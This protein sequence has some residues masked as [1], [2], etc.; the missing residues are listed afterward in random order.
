M[1]STLRPLWRAIRCASSTR[2]AALCLSSLW[3]G[4]SMP[5]RW[6]CQASNRVAIFSSCCLIK[7][8]A[9][10]LLFDHTPHPFNFFRHSPITFLRP[11]I[12]WEWRISTL[13]EPG[14]MKDEP[15]M[16]NGVCL[17]LTKTNL[18]VL[19]ANLQYHFLKNQVLVVATGFDTHVSHRKIFIGLK[20]ILFRKI[21]C[22]EEL[23]IYWVG[24]M[25]KLGK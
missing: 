2:W 9:S 20:E 13:P 18:V 12:V 3:E 8:T 5:W 16:F 10:S 24:V 17:V 22:V 4:N 25:R 23:L 21:L 19:P 6:Y 11:C 14:P 7:P 1:E 15:D